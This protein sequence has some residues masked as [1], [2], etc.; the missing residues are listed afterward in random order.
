MT[1]FKERAGFL[2]CLLLVGVI[3]Y[4]DRLTG[5]DLNMSPFYLVP[6]GLA[7]WYV[8]RY[9]AV[10]IACCVGIVWAWVDYG[11]PYPHAWLY[12]WNA[13]MRFIGFL[14]FGIIFR[15]IRDVIT[16]QQEVIKEL[17]NTF[18]E[19]WKIGGLFP[20]CSMCK[21]MRT[22]AEYLEEI[23]RYAEEHPNSRFIHGICPHC[24]ELEN[25]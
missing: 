21:K 25:N 15:A 20:I 9:S 11:H 23:K 14:A 17:T 5:Y 7:A 8:G 16:S 10:V 1:I 24:K 4:A 6:M 19:S 18:E 13:G 12:Y 22:D 2:G 3:G